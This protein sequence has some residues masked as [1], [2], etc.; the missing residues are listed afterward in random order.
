MPFSF[1]NS[2]QLPQV[3]CQSHV[4]KSGPGKL[5]GLSVGIKAAL[6][7]P[8]TNHL[9][10]EQIRGLPSGATGTAALGF[11]GCAANPIATC[12]SN[13]P[14]SNGHCS[15]KSSNIATNGSRQAV[16]MA[17]RFDASALHIQHGLNAT[18]LQS[19]YRPPVEHAKI[20]EFLVS[21]LSICVRAYVDDRIRNVPFC[22][23][24]DLGSNIDD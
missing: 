16:S 11:Q 18:K 23:M 13:G 21:S 20:Q 10:N 12:T 3:Y 1:C 17:G 9:V 14:T 24:A 2:N 7:A 8:K 15:N 4:P 6:T 22:M 19:N 5:D